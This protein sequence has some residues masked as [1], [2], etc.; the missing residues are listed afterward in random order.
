MHENSSVNIF[1][2]Q[3]LNDKGYSLKSDSFNPCQD[4]DKKTFV[5]STD[6]HLQKGAD[7]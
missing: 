2:S 6:N 1:N 5:S 3:G 4:I 7:I